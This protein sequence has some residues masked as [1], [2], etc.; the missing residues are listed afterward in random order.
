MSGFMIA[1][2][3][4]MR[5][6]PAE[7]QAGVLVGRVAKLP[8]LNVTLPLNVSVRHRPRPGARCDATHARPSADCRHGSPRAVPAES[9]PVVDPALLRSRWRSARPLAAG[10]PPKAAAT[11][12]SQKYRS[13]G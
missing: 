11:G 2:A 8:R 7:I 10:W 6:I 12:R 13:L 4:Q 5:R 9:S 1:V 3:A